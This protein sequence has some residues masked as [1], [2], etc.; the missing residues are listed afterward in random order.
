MADFDI[1]Q[2]KTRKNNILD[3]VLRINQSLKSNVTDYYWN[4]TAQNQEEAKKDINDIYNYLK[5]ASLDINQ[6]LSDI[7]NQ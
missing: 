6:I 3:R 1:E 2:A 5:N 4:T 7:D